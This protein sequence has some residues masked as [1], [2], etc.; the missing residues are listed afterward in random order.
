M[1]FGKLMEIRALPEWRDQYLSYKKLKR[2]S[3]LL[4]AAEQPPF[5]GTDAPLLGVHVAAESKMEAQFFA[6]LEE[7]LR[8]IN[9]H[10]QREQEL[11]SKRVL[12]LSQQH[13]SFCTSATPSAGMYTTMATRIDLTVVF[14]TYCDCARLRSFVQLNSEGVRKV[15]G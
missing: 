1:K 12:L 4:P 8:R 11:I 10:A 15:C 13:A 7:D 2:I 5:Q 3:K 9:L 6:T 14:A